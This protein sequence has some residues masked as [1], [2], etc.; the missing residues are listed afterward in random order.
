MN[1]GKWCFGWRGVL[2]GSAIVVHQC[3]PN[4]KHNLDDKETSFG[5]KVFKF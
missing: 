4:I 5:A 3:P 1:R 2:H